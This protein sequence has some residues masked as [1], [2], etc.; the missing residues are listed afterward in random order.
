MVVEVL[1]I[2]AANGRLVVTAVGHGLDCPSERVVWE[3][4]G[5][6]NDC[7]T[8]VVAVGDMVDSHV[9][10]GFHAHAIHWPEVNGRMIRIFGS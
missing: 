7:G 6:V 1:Q 5:P 8:A 4:A 10:L 2:S 3:S 9:E